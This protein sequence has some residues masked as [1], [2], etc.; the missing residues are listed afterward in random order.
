MKYWQIYK[1][2]T[3]KEGLSKY[4]YSYQ[5]Y[6]LQIKQNIKSYHKYHKVCRQELS[7]ALKRKNNFINNIKTYILE[8]LNNCNF[9]HKAVFNSKESIYK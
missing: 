4:M 9:F 3:K 6:I 2:L 1:I 5:V 8:N 7:R